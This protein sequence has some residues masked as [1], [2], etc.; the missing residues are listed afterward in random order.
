MNKPRRLWRAML[1]VP[2]NVR[3]FVEKA[4]QAGADAVVLD[5]EDSVPHDRKLEARAGLAE[6]PALTRTRHRAALTEALARL[7]E[8]E[9][10]PLPELAAEAYRGAVMA[11]GRLT[12]RVGVENVLDIVFGDFCI[13]K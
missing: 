6:A 10:A 1:Y 5:L 13:G 2:S 11:L 8:A 9:T 4:P 12:G 7:T 3:R